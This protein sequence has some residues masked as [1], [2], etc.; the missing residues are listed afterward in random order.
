MDLSLKLPEK[1][2]VKKYEK[3]QELEEVSPKK[4]LWW[5]I[6]LGIFL[7]LIIVTGGF[8]IYKTFAATKKI[9]QENVSGGAPVLQDKISPKELK[10]EGDGR[11]NI[12]L[13][14]MGGEGHAGEYLTDTIMVVSIDPKNKKV[15]MLSIPRDFYLYIPKHGYNRIN[16]MYYAGEQNKNKGGGLA[17]SKEVISDL[18]DINI[19]Y[20]V[21]IDFTGFKDIVNTL[22]GVTVDVEKDLVDTQY[23][24]SKGGYQTFKVRKGTQKMDGELAL[25]YARSRHSTSD[26]DRAARQQKVL[27]AIKEKALKMETILNPTKIAGLLDALGNHLKT[28]IQ[29]WEIQRLIDISRGIDASKIVNKVINGEEG[30]VKTTMINGMSVVVPVSG[31]YSEI[32][33]FAHEL[34]I[35]TYIT[36]ENA[37]VLVLA[38]TKNTNA[39]KKLGSMLKSYNYNVIKIDNASKLDYK[40][41]I[42]YDNTKGSKP[43]TLEFLKKRLEKLSL[44]PEIKQSSEYDADIIIII[45]SDYKG[46]S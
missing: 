37:R 3:V 7:G 27:V 39:A 4:K 11:I 18:L 42:I 15:A 8:L 19:H 21:A 16:T 1:K 22:G 23:P 34:F 31:D 45:G 25:K 32:R 33:K 6:P 35:D 2:A 46:K 20:A 38:G 43:Y 14:G 13:L 17:K 44:R 12:L 30:L 10:G 9:V 41:T 36:D 26:F 40:N 28:D 5:E 24:T 29:L